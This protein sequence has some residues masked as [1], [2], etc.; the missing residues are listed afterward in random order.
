MRVLITGSSGFLG[1]HWLR[2]FADTDHDI[3]TIDLNPSPYGIPGDIGDMVEWLDGFDEQV[4]R[5]YHFA[6][7]VGGRMKIELDPLYN[8]DALRLDQAIFRWARDHAQTLIYPSS[9]A[10][11]PVFA[12]D[13]DSRF[14][15]LNEAMVDVREDRWGRPD[16]LYGF[17]KLAGEVLAWTAARY[18]LRTLVIRPF[19]GYGPGQ[20]FDYPVPSIAR[21]AVLR[22]DPIVIWGSGT[23]IRDFVHVQ[24]IIGATEARLAAGIEPHHKSGGAVA[25]MNIASGVATSFRTVARICAELVGYQP[26]ITNDES[27]PQGVALRHGDDRIMAS[28]YPQKLIGLRDGLDTVVKDVLD[29]IERGLDGRT[30]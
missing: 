8:A 7:P 5:V 13:I 14:G 19:S 11:Y 10:V 27:K 18:G 17:T 2:H 4:D 20:S 22:E 24:D 23:Q 29:R 15:P 16:E 6:S 25:V 1:S 9:S 30:H 12:Q 21:R 3:W 28:Y 26:L